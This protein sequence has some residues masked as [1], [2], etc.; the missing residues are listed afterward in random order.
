MIRFLVFFH[1]CFSS[2]LRIFILAFRNRMVPYVRPT[3]NRL[4]GFEPRKEGIQERPESKLEIR[5]P[6]PGLTFRTTAGLPKLKKLGNSFFQAPPG[7]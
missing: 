6:F 7:F 5:Q 4:G 3:R 1:Y 2:Q